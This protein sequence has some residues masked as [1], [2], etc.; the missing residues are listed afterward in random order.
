MAHYP[1]IFDF[2]SGSIDLSEISFGTGTGITSSSFFKWDESR[3]NLLASTSSN[4]GKTCCSYRS[5][6]I[7]GKCNCIDY[8]NDSSII[9]GCL[10]EILSATNSNTIIGGRCS[11]IKN[12]GF[13]TIIGGWSS[14]VIGTSS[15]MTIVNSPF[16]VI[17]ASQTQGSVGSSIFG[18]GSHLIDVGS[19][20]SFILGGNANCI[21]CS[22]N[23]VIIGG[24]SLC[25]QNADKLVYIPE[26]KLHT[27]DNFQ[28]GSCVLIW[29]N[30]K[31]VRY[32]TIQS[33][34]ASMSLIATSIDFREV[35]FGNASSTGITS[36]NNF[37]YEVQNDLVIMGSSASEIRTTNLFGGVPNNPIRGSIISSFTSSIGPSSSNNSVISSVGSCIQ[38]R[39]CFG[40]A[41][42]NT[43]ISS[44]GIRLDSNINSSVISSSMSGGGIINNRFVSIIASVA[45]VPSGSSY[46]MISSSRLVTMGSTVK[47]SSIDSSCSSCITNSG[48]FSS[49]QSTCL[50]QIGCC[51]SMSTIQ[52]SCCSRILQ[53]TAASTILGGSCNYF[54]GFSIICRVINSVILGG[55]CNRIRCH[56]TTAGSVI[57]GSLNSCA[58]CSSGTIQSSVGSCLI[59]TAVN[60]NRFNSIISSSASSICGG[61]INSSIENSS[62]GVI[63]GI[64]GVSIA[65]LTSCCSTIE[66]NAQGTASTSNS[67]MNSVGTSFMSG[68]KQSIIQG[69]SK[70]CLISTTASSIIGGNC[71]L[72]FDD[73]GSSEISSYRGSICSSVRSSIISASSSLICRSQHSL[74]STGIGNCILSSTFSSIES[75]ECSIIRNSSESSIIATCLSSITFSSNS[76]IIGG[77]CGRIVSSFNS[78]IIGG[79]GLTLSNVSNIVYV[80][81]LKI[82]TASISNSA[83]RVLVWDCATS[84]VFWRC[85]TSIGGSP[86]INV[87]QIAF[88]CD[89][90]IG[91]TSSSALSFSQSTCN[92]KIG[93]SVSYFGK[94]TC[95]SVV[96]SGG[97]NAKSANVITGSSNIISGANYYT[98]VDDSKYSTI[99]SGLKNFLTKGY[100]SSIISSG[101]IIS[102]GICSSSH[103]ASYLGT[104]CDSFRS[105]VISTTNFCI[106]SSCYSSI[107]GGSNNTILSST[108][109][110]IIGGKGLTLSNVNN[111][112]ITP[113]LCVSGALSL[114]VITASNNITLGTSNFTLLAFAPSN[115]AGM[116]VSLPSASVARHRMYVIKKMDASTQSFVFIKP[117]SGDNI[118][119]TTT[120]ITL[121]SPYDYNMLQSDGANTWIKLGGAVGINL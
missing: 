27:A 14:S 111:Q 60:E 49:I 79:T 18:G 56:T 93:D 41:S 72:I 62:F 121:E 112:V 107:I 69:G 114:Q 84:D 50:S 85:D 101:S 78:A 100:H 58:D 91:I 21:E 82:A 73:N 2:T 110:V 7:G 77:E 68:T 89:N 94:N 43:I 22:S 42:Q 44:G 10:N 109:S 99:L 65:M 11:T 5:A 3:V 71:N 59:S 117:N 97:P 29:D 98:K 54:G 19:E 104:I 53:N 13:S 45:A 119:G 106:G 105:S 40:I 36:S 81:K 33:L 95:R 48:Y 55:F 63:N 51:V 25:I 120:Y 87:S 66:S 15:F 102:C 38:F 103:I 108:S 23:S 35:A 17:K 28:E 8:G 115:G 116:T 6:I 96:I 37:T 92:T 86:L 83:P 57:L 88:G 75:S 39:E 67:T 70:Q 26:L 20:N 46:A 12:A 32:R 34:A 113:S 47:Y 31:Y 80:P 9:G 24:E 118:E 1:K 30:D 4:F 90:S 61:I 74:V 76:T 64:C 16:S 52:A